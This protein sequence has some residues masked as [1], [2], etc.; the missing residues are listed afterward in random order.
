M[1]RIF[2]QMY[3]VFQSLMITGQVLFEWL[4]T[5]F[6]DEIIAGAFGTITPMELMFGGSLIIVLGLWLAKFILK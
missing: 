1:E 3:L 2:N 4:F 6:E 5:P